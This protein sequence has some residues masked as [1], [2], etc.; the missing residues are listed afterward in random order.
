[1]PRGSG[2]VLARIGSAAPCARYRALA[3]APDSRRDTPQCRAL[4]ARPWAEL[5]RVHRDR[6]QIRSQ[7]SRHRVTGDARSHNAVEERK[8]ETRPDSGRGRTAAPPVLGHR[9]QRGVGVAIPS[10]RELDVASDEWST[11]LGS[12]RLL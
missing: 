6:Q 11:Q 2:T 7:Q 10:E 1:G 3:S 9:F 8:S 4:T 5:Y 12:A